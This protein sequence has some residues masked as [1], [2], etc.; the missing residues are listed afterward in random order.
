MSVTLEMKTRI[1]PGH[2][3]EI[4]APELP[5]G[6]EATVVIRVEDAPPAKRPLRE[7]LGEYRGGQLFRSAEEVDAYL[8]QE[9]ESWDR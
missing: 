8:R 6:R 7:V 9:R 1:L 5:V 3:I 2:R 4:Q